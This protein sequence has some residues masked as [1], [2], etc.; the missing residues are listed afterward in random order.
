MKTIHPLRQSPVPGFISTSEFIFEPLLPDHVALDY[1]AVMSSKV[2]LRKWSQSTWPTDNFTLDENLIDLIRHSQEHINNLAY[3]YTILNIDRTR[4]LGCI[5]IKPVESITA[6]TSEEENKLR[7]FDAILSFW[8]RESLQENQMEQ[9]IIDF[10]IK[11][12]K[13]TWKFNEL[14]FATNDLIPQQISMFE[15]NGLY[16]WMKLS[17]PNRYQTLWK[18]PK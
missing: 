13:E 15:K 16:L 1:E 17:N 18:I 8:V 6:N 7:T 5:Y 11:W 9:S 2:F 4:C 10:L 3:T 14:V 12:M